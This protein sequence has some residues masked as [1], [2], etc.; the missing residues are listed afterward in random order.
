LVVVLTALS[1]S[2]IPALR[3]A[4]TDPVKAMRTF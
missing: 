3:A 4:K 2:L 1:V